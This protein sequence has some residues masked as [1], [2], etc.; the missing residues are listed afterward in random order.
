[1]TVWLLGFTVLCLLAIAVGAFIFTGE[2]YE[3]RPDY[4]WCVKCHHYHKGECE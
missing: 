4:G 1:M 3:S 2:E